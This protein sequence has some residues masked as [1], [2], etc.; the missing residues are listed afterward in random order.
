[1]TLKVF[2]EENYGHD[3][4][5]VPLQNRIGNLL[6]VYVIVDVICSDGNGMF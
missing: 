3:G 1:M 2:S 5:E 6:F 4:E